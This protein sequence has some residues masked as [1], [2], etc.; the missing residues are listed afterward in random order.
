MGCRGGAVLGDDFCRRHT[1]S[2]AACAC[3][4]A[5]A[6]SAGAGAGADRFALS[7]G[8]PHTG[9]DWL[10][11]LRLAAV[12][13]LAEPPRPPAL[14]SVMALTESWK[15]PERESECTSISRLRFHQD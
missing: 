15:R 3:A 8:Q 4:V 11:M 7:L 13:A 14:C 9:S 1:A 5:I 10:Q 2:A 12:G 6:A